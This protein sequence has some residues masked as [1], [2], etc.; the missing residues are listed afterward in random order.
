MIWEAHN[1]IQ[2]WRI[3]FFTRFYFQGRLKE[4]TRNLISSETTDRRYA[5]I[6]TRKTFSNKRSYSFFLFER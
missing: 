1:D 4:H 6:S 5:Q 2:I 3:R